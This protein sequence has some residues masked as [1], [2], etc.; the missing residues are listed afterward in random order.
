MNNSLNSRV[1]DCREAA[2]R[3]ADCKLLLPRSEVRGMRPMTERVT[4]WRGVTPAYT[5]YAEGVTDGEGGR[6]ERVPNGRAV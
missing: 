1:A 4:Q 6:E 3:R 5:Y 2:S